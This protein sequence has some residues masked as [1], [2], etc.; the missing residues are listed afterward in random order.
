MEDGS[1]AIPPPLRGGLTTVPEHHGFRP[2][3][4]NS[5]RGYSPAPL[6][7]ERMLRRKCHAPY[8]STFFVESHL[9]I[10]YDDTLAFSV[11]VL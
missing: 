6:R 1:I 2:A 5:T 11:H 10:Q 8:L 7:G 4:P 3:V 9:T